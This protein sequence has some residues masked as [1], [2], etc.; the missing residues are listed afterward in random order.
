MFDQV[1]TVKLDEIPEISGCILGSVVDV[2]DCTCLNVTGYRIRTNTRHR[3]ALVFRQISEP[4][5]EDRRVDDNLPPEG[6]D[7]IIVLMHDVRS[8]LYV[9]CIFSTRLLLLG[10]AEIYRR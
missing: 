10:V 2:S 5:C 7:K 6:S 1:D 8:K 3:A 9:Q 4:S